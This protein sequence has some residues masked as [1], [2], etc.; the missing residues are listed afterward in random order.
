MTLENLS[1]SKRLSIH[2]NNYQ[3]SKSSLI[4]HHYNFQFL[5]IYP[6]LSNFFVK[7]AWSVRTKIMNFLVKLLA[8]SLYLLRAY[9]DTQDQGRRTGKIL[10]RVLNGQKFRACGA[11]F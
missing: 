6:I 8:V 11:K 7:W 3:V 9:Y 2:A 5:S 1:S 4:F 10:R